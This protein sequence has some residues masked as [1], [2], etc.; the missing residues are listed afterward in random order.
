ML[1]GVFVYIES[2][3]V[4]WRNLRA[5]QSSIRFRNASERHFRLEWSYSTWSY[6]SIQTNGPNQAALRRYCTAKCYFSNMWGVLVDTIEYSEAHICL[7]LKST[8]RSWIKLDGSSIFIY[9]S[10]VKMLTNIILQSKKYLWLLKARILAVFLSLDMRTNMSIKYYRR[11]EF[12][13]RAIGRRNRLFLSLYVHVNHIMTLKFVLS[14]YSPV[15]YN[16]KNI[17][18]F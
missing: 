12:R 17:I 2:F 9:S 13:I 5:N 4:S 11:W 3:L 8:I 14:S 10:V 16:Y 15:K 6:R 1:K 7:L 18:F